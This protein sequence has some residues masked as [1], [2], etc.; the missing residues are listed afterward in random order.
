M[1]EATERLVKLFLESKGF[2]V[3][4]NEKVKIEKNR[5][6]EIDIIAVRL[7]QKEK[8]SLPNK[9]IGEVK[10]W[11]LKKD[12]DSENGRKKFKIIIDDKE[13]IEKYVNDNY[14]RGFK[15]VIFAR[16]IPKKHR[17]EVNTKLK[18]R[19]ISF[20]SLEE[21]V[22]KIVSYAEE[23]GYTNDSELQLLRLLKKFKV[24]D[25]A[26]GDKFNRV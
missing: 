22:E 10:S 1:E 25:G 8:D 4:T 15:Q 13:K 7:K 24:M 2:L 18:N 17:K 5:T 12:F 6:L 3:K 19:S 9:I 20:V 21:V 23:H 16:T 26:R 11:A 14:G